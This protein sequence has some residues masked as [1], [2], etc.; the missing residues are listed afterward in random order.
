MKCELCGGTIIGYSNCIICSKPFAKRH[1]GQ[2]TCASKECRKARQLT[3]QKEWKHRL[4][5][6]ARFPN[7]Y[8]ICVI[9]GDEVEKVRTNQATC[10]S[11]I[12]LQKHGYSHKYRGLKAKH[13]YRNL[14]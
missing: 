14:G 2:I 4:T 7:E 3:M 12:C 13:V 5:K 6:I 8:V 11:K 9:C 1:Q 10:F